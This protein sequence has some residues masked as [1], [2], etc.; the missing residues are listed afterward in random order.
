[1]IPLIEG[2]IYKVYTIKGEVFGAKFCGIDKDGRL[3]STN[4]ARLT[5]WHKETEVDCLESV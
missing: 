2:A 1:M 4:S 5:T 3:V